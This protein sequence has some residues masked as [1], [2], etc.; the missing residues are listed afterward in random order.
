MNKNHETPDIFW[1]D[2]KPLPATA[3]EGAVKVNKAQ[4]C[5]KIISENGLKPYTDQELQLF[6]ASPRNLVYGYNST[7]KEF[8]DYSIAS[9]AQSKTLYLGRVP[10]DVATMIENAIGGKVD[11]YN[12]VLTNGEIRK[13][14]ADHGSNEKE[15]SRGQ[16]AV[17]PTLLECLPDVLSKPDAVMQG[18]PAVNQYGKAVFQMAKAINGYMVYVQAVSDRGLRLR[19]VTLYIINKKKPATTN[20]AIT[21]PAH[22]V[23]NESGAVSDFSITKSGGDVNNFSTSR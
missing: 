18:N 13:I 11:N 8:I 14:L 19:P 10:D 15:A 3:L 20:N 4:E 2:Q 7:L 12:Y 1:Q 22:N 5:A 9:K 16:I 21:G 23:P 17:T 6:T